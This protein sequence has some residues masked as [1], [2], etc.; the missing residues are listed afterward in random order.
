MFLTNSNSLNF[1]T[2]RINLPLS[3]G[4][5]IKQKKKEEDGIRNQGGF[6]SGVKKGRKKH[7]VRNVEQSRRKSPNWR[8]HRNLL[9]LIVWGEMV[10]R[11]VWATSWEQSPWES[12]CLATSVPST[13]HVHQAREFLKGPPKPAG[14]RWPMMGTQ[15][16][17]EIAQLRSLGVNRC[18]IFN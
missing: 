7:D 9:T 15:T 18:R 2:F 12:A 11:T 10:A 6:E 8:P 14:I 3:Q 4:R 1:I 5:V 13:C 16:F 17:S